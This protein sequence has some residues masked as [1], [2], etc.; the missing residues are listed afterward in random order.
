MVETR[1]LDFYLQI[2]FATYPINPSRTNN[3]RSL[4]QEMS[5]FKQYLELI[6]ANDP[7]ISQTSEFITYYALPYVPNPLEHKSFKHL[8]N[9]EFISQ[10]KRKLDGYIDTYLRRP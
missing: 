1:K 3:S 10:I 6:V 5:M 7:L 8:F 4:N 2:Y 9:P